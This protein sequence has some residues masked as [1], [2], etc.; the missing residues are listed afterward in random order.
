MIGGR[1]G[2]VFFPAP[3]ADKVY[4]NVQMI[5]GT[6]KERTIDM[7]AEFERALDVAAHRLAREG[8]IVVRMSLMKV[9]SEVGR[10]GLSAANGAHVGGLIVELTPS[11]ERRVRRPGGGMAR[12]TAAA[13]ARYLYH[14]GSAGRPPGRDVDISFRETMSTRQLR[15]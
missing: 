15:R 2:F 12:R 4:G 10:P 8:E 13:G 3:E 9:G 11:D 1:V 5:A 7:L 6:P 14:P